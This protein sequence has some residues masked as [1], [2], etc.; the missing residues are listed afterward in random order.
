MLALLPLVL[1]GSAL[2]AELSWR[3]VESPAL[4]LRAGRGRPKAR[5]PLPAEG[6]PAAAAAGG[7]LP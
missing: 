7:S 3:L 2:V 4:R 6:R 5:A 1:V